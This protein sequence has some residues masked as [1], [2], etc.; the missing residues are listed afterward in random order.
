MEMREK[1]RE[2]RGENKSFRRLYCP[3]FWGAGTLGFFSQALGI[4]CSCFGLSGA[5]DLS[6]LFRALRLS[7][8]RA[9]AALFFVFFFSAP[10]FAQSLPRVCFA[11]HCFTVEIADEPDEH[12][13]GLMFRES[14]PPENGMLFIF[15]REARYGFWMKNM[16][17]PLDIIWLDRNMRIVF[18]QKN[19]QP[20][21]DGPC[22]SYRPSAAARYVLELNAGTT[23]K[24]GFEPGITM[25]LFD[26]FNNED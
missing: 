11:E 4:C 14:L 9:L 13:R 8:S 20:C 26:R 24:A 17:I 10:A 18:I 16:R 15:D 21:S 25:E 7:D 1:K 23:D 19:A 12:R 3:G 22:K 6:L 5:Q 2:Y